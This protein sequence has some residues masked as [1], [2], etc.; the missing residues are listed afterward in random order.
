MTL[1]RALVSKAVC[2]HSSC[3]QK[4]DISFPLLLEGVQSKS[5]KISGAR[6][7]HAS[8]RSGALL[9]PDLGSWS[10]FRCGSRERGL[11]ARRTRTE[12]VFGGNQ[13]QASKPGP[14]RRGRKRAECVTFMSR[15]VTPL[16]SQRQTD[17]RPQN[18]SPFET[19]ELGVRFGKG[20]HVGL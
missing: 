6:V 14:T 20:Y 7:C 12:E 11:D 19:R 16:R 8:S 3:T 1:L 15:G 18:V 9:L 2:I 17:L 10:S 13:A 5:L 4:L